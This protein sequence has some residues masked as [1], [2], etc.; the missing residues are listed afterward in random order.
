MKTDA[1]ASVFLCKNPAPGARELIFLF[2]KRIGSDHGADEIK[3]RQGYEAK[4]IVIHVIQPVAGVFIGL[5]KSDGGHEHVK[6]QRQQGR[7]FRLRRM[8]SAKCLLKS[9]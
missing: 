2:E 1:E 4:K 7:N 6:R 8:I 9:S 5:G 3:H